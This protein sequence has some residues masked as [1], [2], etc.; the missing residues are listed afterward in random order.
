MALTDRESH[1][2]SL[3]ILTVHGP[4]AMNGHVGDVIPIPPHQPPQRHVGDVFRRDNC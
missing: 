4:E 3:S 2:S 1:P